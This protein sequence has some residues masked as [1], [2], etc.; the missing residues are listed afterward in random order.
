MAVRCARMIALKI[1][2]PVSFTVMRWLSLNKKLQAR[3]AARGTGFAMRQD[4]ISLCKSF[5]D[6]VNTRSPETSHSIAQMFYLS[7]LL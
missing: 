2:R 6:D 4:N 7:I 1:Q 3:I 5:G